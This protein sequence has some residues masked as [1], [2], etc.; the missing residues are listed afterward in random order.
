MAEQIFNQN[1]AFKI[2]DQY[3]TG[4]RYEV[5]LDGEQLAAGTIKFMNGRKPIAFARVESREEAVEMLGERN[6]EHMETGKGQKKESTIGT[7]NGTLKG[8]LQS[9]YLAYQES[10]TKDKRPENT[11]EAGIDRQGDLDTEVSAWV[12]KRREQLIYSRLHSQNEHFIAGQDDI[13]STD[14]P[15]TD[16]K[17]PAIKDNTEQRT[18]DHLKAIPASVKERFIQV[19]NQYYFPDKTY[20]FGDRGTKLVTRS[21]NQEVIRSIVAIA[22]AREWNRVTVRGTEDFRRTAWLQ[23]SLSGIEVSGYQPSKVEKAHLEILF[24]RSGRE[25]SLEPSTDRQQL[26][27]HNIT[28]QPEKVVKTPDDPREV[29]TMD[30][31]QKSTLT[32]PA[33]PV[34]SPAVLRASVITGKLLEHGAARYQNDS[35][36]ELSYFVKVDTAQGEQTLWGVDLERAVAESGVTRGEN[37][38]VEKQGSKPVTARERLFDEN[39]KEVGERPI[40]THRNKWRVGSVDKAEAFANG[41]RAD[42]VKKYPDLA[43]LYGTVAAAYKFAE[44]QFPDSKENQARF[45]TIARQVVTE[46]IAHG[47]PVPTPKIREANV[48]KHPKKQSKHQEQSISSQKQQDTEQEKD[49]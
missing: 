30:A 22:K 18:A 47:E 27:T 40:N 49:R 12:A 37:I 20:A 10:Y 29:A 39:N 38:T 25:N 11:L 45:M 5:T 31:R 1:G 2:N 42:A 41:D 34:I 16:T 35:K 23:A 13:S 44:Q 21:E 24:D 15:H 33:I 32:T 17:T 26:T 4:I 43:P 28:E 8:K 6:V 19:D 14:R 48:Q 7:T 36:K 9:K 46:K 3:A